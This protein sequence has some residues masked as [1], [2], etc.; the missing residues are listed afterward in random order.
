MRRSHIVV[1]VHLV[2]ATYQ[3]M[4]LIQPEWED[5]LYHCIA[6]D[7]AKLRCEIL[8][9]NGMPDHVHLAVMLP[10]TV[11]IASIMKQVKGNSSNFITEQILPK[12]S[13]FYWQ[14]G[15]S[16]YGF[17]INLT[18]RVVSYIQNQKKHHSGGTVWPTL[19][20]IGEELPEE[21]KISP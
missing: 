7:A 16:A 20:S 21:P 4:P 19:E 17:H 18:P 14:E 5:D 6:Q 15:Y 1:P 9:L 10:A 13:F 2:W 3:R 11:T 8:A 12:D